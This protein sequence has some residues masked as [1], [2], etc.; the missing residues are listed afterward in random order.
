MI[1]RRSLRFRLVALYM[2]GSFL[3]FATLGLVAITIVFALA[4]QPLAREHARSVLLVERVA[5]AAPANEPDDSILRRIV[6]RLHAAGVVAVALSAS[7]MREEPT[8]SAMA[9]IINI[10]S[11]FG[12]A[13][14]VVSVRGSGI[15]VFANH[16]KVAQTFA[17]LDVAV[18]FTLL[19]AL[20]AAWVVARIGTR[21][22]LAPLVTVTAE[23]ERFAS[24]DFAPASLEVADRTEFGALAAA[25]NGA[26]R[27]VTEAFLERRR[28]EEQIRQFVA[29]AGH[30][31]RTPLTVVAGYVDVLRR[32]GLEDVTLRTEAFAA[33]NVEI[34]RMRTLVERLVTLARL[35]RISDPEVEIVDVGAILRQVVE[36][37]AT[38]APASL[39]LDVVGEPLLLGDPADTYDA[40]SNLMENA[41]KYG[42]GTRVL[43]SARSE[44]G[45][46][47]VRVTDGGP[48]IS[49]AERDR[50]FERFYRGVES[51]GTS[52]SGLGLAIAARAAER[53]GGRVVLEESRP[54]ST[55][56]TLIVPGVETLGSTGTRSA[57][58]T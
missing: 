13:P 48:G 20:W 57:V 53:L 42:R 35:D 50:I 11:L 14:A 56:F 6:E 58:R 8:P 3:V 39:A 54:G 32:A 5:A 12:L 29:E 30:Q 18:A 43:V 17:A 16:T 24:G 2:T 51:D 4:T 7:A 37:L 27:N 23:L 34:K 55:T 26:A 47:V 36:S 31:L 15:V 40:V 49:D 41:I 10:G 25:Y 45:S 38:I 44:R 28:V 21:Q 33:L 1:D 9:G 22:A 19:A 46:V 52:G